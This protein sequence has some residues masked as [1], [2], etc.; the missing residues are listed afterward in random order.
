MCTCAHT[1]TYIQRET[2]RKIPIVNSQSITRSRITTP[3]KD[4]KKSLSDE[5]KRKRRGG[6]GKQEPNIQAHRLRFHCP[7]SNKRYLLLFMRVSLLVQ[8]TPS[9][10]LPKQDEGC[11][12]IIYKVRR[13]WNSSLL[14]AHLQTK[15]FRLVASSKSQR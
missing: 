8:T 5:E 14:R 3:W 13:N 1:Q 15:K 2:E 11:M 7:D 6:R 4:K 10:A 9:E 12:L